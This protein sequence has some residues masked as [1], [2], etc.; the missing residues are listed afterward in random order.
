MSK[1]GQL[2][3]QIIRSPKLFVQSSIYQFRESMFWVGHDDEA[4]GTLG[5]IP[6]RMPPWSYTAQL[7]IHGGITPRMALPQNK[8]PATTKLESGME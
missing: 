6:P 7:D 4:T 2:V 1:L 3:A 5:V 8:K